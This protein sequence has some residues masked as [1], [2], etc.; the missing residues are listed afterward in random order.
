MN[1][2]VS[3]LNNFLYRFVVNVG[4]SWHSYEVDKCTITCS[5]DRS[6]SRFLKSRTLFS[7]QALRTLFLLTTLDIETHCYLK[8]RSLITGNLNGYWSK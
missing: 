7:A 6:D 4:S 8:S 5:R 3:L 1:N 2:N